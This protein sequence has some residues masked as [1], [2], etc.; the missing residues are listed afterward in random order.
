MQSLCIIEIFLNQTSRSKLK[1]FNIFLGIDPT[2]FA[3]L[4]Q[5]IGCRLIIVELPCI[6]TLIFFLFFSFP[7]FSPSNYFIFLTILELIFYFPVSWLHFWTL[8]LVLFLFVFVAFITCFLI[9]HTN[10]LISL[11]NHKYIARTT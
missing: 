4:F 7:F 2:T 5:F 1:I 11:L 10:L 8:T 6:F 3:A 9:A